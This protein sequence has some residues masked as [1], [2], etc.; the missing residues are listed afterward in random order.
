MSQ[1]SHE[2]RSIFAKLANTPVWG[3]RRGV[4]SF[5]TMEFGVP[6]L[7]IREP[8]EAAP[9]I[10]E[11]ARIILQ[12]RHVWVR[13]D[14]HLWIE[15]CDWAIE[16]FGLKATCKSK[17]DYI[18]RTLKTIEGQKITDFSGRHEESNYIV[19]LIFDLGGSVKIFWSHADYD[20]VDALSLWPTRGPTTSM[21]IDGLIRNLD[22]ASDSE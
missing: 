20:G 18:D 1:F 10:P 19:E 12:R 11:S 13:G 21:G 14:W 15:D 17:S 2:V 5:L 9:N 3:V 16:S 4:G 22:R 8:K 6:H 7:E